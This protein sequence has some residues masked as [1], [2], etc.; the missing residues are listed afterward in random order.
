MIKKNNKSCKYNIWEDVMKIVILGAAGFIGT[1]LALELCKQ[2]ELLL[3]DSCREYFENSPLLEESK[4]QIY[5]IGDWKKADYSEVLWNAEMVFHL[6]STNNPTTSNTNIGAELEENVALTVNILEAC[7]KNHVGKIIFLSSGGTIYGAGRCPLDEE[8]PTNPINTYGI[9]KLAI[10]KIIYLYNYLYGIDYRI[11]RLANPYGP[12]QRPNGKLGAVTTFTYKAL[13]G[14]EIKIFGDGSNIRDY[15]YISDAVAAI[16][17]IAMQNTIYKVYNVGSGIGIS[18]V[19]M[20][21]CI[22]KQLHKKVAVCFS[23]SRNVDLRENYLDTTRY[24][25]EFGDVVTISLQEGILKTA[26]FLKEHYV[27]RGE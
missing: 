18:L 5:T 20:L 24:V 14:E 7:K 2:N 9:Q 26:D 11:V 27:M 3:V 21:G 16:I 4:V 22:E 6:V 12:Y 10:E 19:D 23:E 15:I 25:N 1:N 17:N 8:A 13:K